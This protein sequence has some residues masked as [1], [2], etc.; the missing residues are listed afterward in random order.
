MECESDDHRIAVSHNCLCFESQH[1]CV[2]LP[3]R[4]G[5]LATVEWLEKI[6]PFLSGAPRWLQIVSLAVF[7]QV[8]AVTFLVAVYTLN[9]EHRKGH[10]GASQPKLLGRTEVRSRGFLQVQTCY[11]RNRRWR[12]SFPIPSA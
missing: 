12:H 1:G 2:E 8:L 6:L 3:T 11:F 4:S 9:S 5:K 7:V 10:R